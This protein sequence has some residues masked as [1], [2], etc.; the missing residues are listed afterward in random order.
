MQTFLPYPDFHNCAQVLDRKRLGKQIVEA[1]QIY[2]TIT[3]PSESKAWR[4]HPAVKMWMGYE[5]ALA[6]YFNACKDEWIS[7]GYNSSLNIDRPT[8]YNKPSWLGYELLHLSHKANLIR[9]MADYYI[10][11]FGH[12]APMDGYWWPVVCGK[13]SK[14]HTKMWEEIWTR[15]SLKS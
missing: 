3:K 7:R 1:K 5:D 4:N 15:I 14:K 9:K 2:D 10:G 11:V 8:S 13:T 6:A 12:I